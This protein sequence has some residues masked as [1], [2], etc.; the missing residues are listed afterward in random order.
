MKNAVA[1]AT[2]NDIWAGAVTAYLVPQKTTRRGQ[3]TTVYRWMTERGTVCD[4]LAN[5]H[6]IDRMIAIAKRSAVFSNVAA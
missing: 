1:T 2:Y 6:G 3:R 5:G 4:G